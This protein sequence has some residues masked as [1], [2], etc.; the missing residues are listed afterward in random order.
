MILLE[1]WI[2]NLVFILFY[3]ISL[4]FLFF[5]FI[6]FLLNFISIFFILN[7][8]KEVWCDIIYDGHIY[9][10]HKSQLHNIKKIIEDSMI[11]N[12]I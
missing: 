12:I 5:T 7:L 9:H 11:N 2:I 6:Y 3:F 1:L 10:S 4:L 8:G